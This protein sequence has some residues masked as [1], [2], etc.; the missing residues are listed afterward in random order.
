MTFNATFNGISVINIVAVSF[1]V[2]KTGVPEENHR[3][4]VIHWKKH[5]DYKQINLFSIKIP[6]SIS[7]KNSQNV[8][9]I[10][11]INRSFI[12]YF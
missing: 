12:L 11:F 9:F 5:S 1:M 2:E 10:L 4:V 3:P 7:K 8:F 6:Y